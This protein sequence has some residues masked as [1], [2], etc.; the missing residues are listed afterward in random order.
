[1]LLVEDSDSAGECEA[2]VVFAGKMQPKGTGLP[3]QLNRKALRW[4]DRRD[5]GRPFFGFLFYDAIMSRKPPPDYPVQFKADDD[6]RPEHE[7][8]I[9]KTAVHFDDGLIGSVLE[10]LETR[11]L[12]DSTVVLI[13]ADHGEEFRESGGAKLQ[14]HGSGFTR[15]QLVTPMV[16][17]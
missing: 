2:E 17:S 5:P 15:H 13:T 7:L 6:S 9:Y 16:L 11:G 4:L 3:H 14:K 12:L 8:A 10:D 1:M